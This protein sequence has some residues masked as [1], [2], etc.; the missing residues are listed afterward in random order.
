MALKVGD[1]ISVLESEES[2]FVLRIIARYHGAMPS[3]NEAIVV[4]QWSSVKRLI[5]L[6]LKENVID[7]VR[8]KGQITLR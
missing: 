6:S 8:G 4:P 5:I 2:S 7:G 3:H 1:G